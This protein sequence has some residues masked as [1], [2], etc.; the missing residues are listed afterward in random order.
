MNA[1]LSPAEEHVSLLEGSYT[2][3][4]ARA[5]TA[6]SLV[7]VLALGVASSG[8]VQATTQ[9]DAEQPKTQAVT[10]PQPT[11]TELE[12]WRKTIINTPRPKKACFESTY[13]DT[14]WHEVAC[15]PPTNK[16]FPPRREKGGVS[17]QTIGGP[18]TDFVAS[19]A[20]HSFEAEGSFPSTT[21]ITSECSMPCNVLTDICPVPP[22]CSVPGSVAND[23][24]LQMNTQTFIGTKACSGAPHPGVWGQCAGWEQFTYSSDGSGGSIQYW[25]VPYGPPGSSC[26]TGWT[27]F[28]YAPTLSDPNPNIFCYYILPASNPAPAVLPTDL[29]SI[30]VTGSAAGVHA[31][32][33]LLVVTVS[34]HAYSSPGDNL[35]TD[36]GSHWQSTEFNIFGDGNDSQAV[37]NIGS[38]I[39]VNNSVNSGTTTAPTYGRLSF[40]GETN[41]LSLACF[42]PLAS[43]GTTI[44]SPSIQFE[45]SNFNY[46]YPIGGLS[47]VNGDLV[48]LSASPDSAAVWGISAGGEVW[49]YLGVG[50]GESPWQQVT[51]GRVEQIS[52]GAGFDVWGVST[53]GNVYQYVYKSGGQG[54]WKLRMA[55][56][57]FPLPPTPDEATWIVRGAVAAASGGTVWAVM[58]AEVVSYPAAPPEF[59]A[60]VYRWND[61]TFELVPF[62]S[63]GVQIEAA[64]ISVGSSTNVWAL[65][66]SGNAFSYTG[67]SKRPWN[68]VSASL[69]AISAAADGT[70]WGIDAEGHAWRYTGPPP[71]KAPSR[72]SNAWKRVEGPGQPLTQISVASAQSIWALDSNGRAYSY[73]TSNKDWTAWNSRP[74]CP[75][76]KGNLALTSIAALA[77][78]GAWGLNTGTGEIWAYNYEP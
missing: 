41:N 36:L 61:K 60:L 49:R 45:E 43:S 44:T 8:A 15:K 5:A 63:A 34:G 25:L 26:P 46:L 13:P 58:T 29:S 78:G 47:H 11:A 48:S 32:D 12:N 14:E 65:G 68:L 17:P 54:S 6:C 24:S 55:N 37:F 22:S 56:G 59:M 30:T 73:S 74:Q 21:G 35:F 40:T 23:Y 9:D 20:G 66:D 52:V 71:P 18:G 42:K 10:A 76:G 3:R 77:S 28:V 64:Q 62:P 33:D 70:V 69:T 50:G 16:L 38:T 19:V 72:G 1:S 2:R 51:P 53:Y 31:A 4:L 75:L 57:A 27:R 7:L 39:V 67:K